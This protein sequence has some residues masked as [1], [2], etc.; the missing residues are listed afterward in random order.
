MTLDGEFVEDMKATITELR[1]E[2]FENLKKGIL[3]DLVYFGIVE[4]INNNL[5]YWLGIQA[6]AFCIAFSD[7]F[8]RLPT[9]KEEIQIFRVIKEEIPWFKQEYARIVSA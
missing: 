7:R 1:H 2:Y 6:S 9:R 5:I 3:G 4:N 8:E